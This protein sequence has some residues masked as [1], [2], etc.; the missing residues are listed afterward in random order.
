[1]KAS[2]RWLRALVPGL[3]ASPRELAD[4]FTSAGLEVEALTEFGIGT[5]QLV[6]AEV[7]KIEPHPSRAKLRLVTIDKGGAEQRVVCGAPNV[8]DPGHMVAFAPLGAHLPAVNMTL[9]PKDI[10]GVTSEGMLCSEAELGL[11][12]SGG[13]DGILVYAPG[14]AKAGTPLRQAVPAV[15]DWILEIGVTPNR[16]DALGHVG[17]AREAAA[18]F[19][20]PFVFPDPAA[21]KR[22]AHGKGIDAFA[23]VDVAD[24]ERCPIYGAA[25]VTEVKIG[26]SPDWLRYRLESLGV[27]AISNVVDITNLVLLEFGQPMHA[28]DLDRVRGAKIEVRRARDGEVLTTLDGQER[29]L[30]SD[31]LV[32]ADGE[33]AVALAGV[34]GGANSEIAPTTSRVLL[35]CAHFT[36]RGVRRTARRHAMHTEASHRF[37]RGVD[38]GPVPDVLAHAASLLTELA[39][40]AAVPGAILAGPGVPRREPIRLRAARMNR[41]IGTPVPMREARGILERLGFA[42]SGGGDDEL[43]AVPPT[44]RPDVS[45]EA[46][47]IEEVLRVRGLDSVPTR[48]PAISPQPPR[49]T[50]LLESRVRRAAVEVGLSE[51]VTYGF[52][53]AKEITALGAPRATITLMNP[54]GEERSVMRTTL[55]PGL[56][57]ALKRARRRGAPDCRLFT[58][59]PRFL[60][61]RGETIADSPAA[62]RAPGQPNLPDEVPSFAAVIAG[63]RGARLGKPE[64]VDVYDAKGV[65]AEIVERVTGRRAT[66]R[67]QSESAR[68]VHLHPRGAGELLVD[69]LFVGTFGPL[70][71][72]AAE[73][74][75][76]E[77][78]C[79]LVE[80]DLR[81]LDRLGHKVPQFAPIPNLPAATRD[82]AVVVHDDVTAGSVAEAIREAAEELCES[83]ELFD[84]FRGG[85]MPADHRSLAYHVVYRDPKAATDPEAART[86]TDEEV[87]ARHKAVVSTV[88]GRFGATLRA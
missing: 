82:I 45:M 6:M 71:P 41:L 50:G 57:E 26:P 33:G 40:G 76:V 70:H 29:K 2:H 42:V 23:R 86:L 79:M 3:D 73:A 15:H 34:M 69:G 87:D 20:L 11:V 77:G 35:E 75:E 16:P 31:D 44:H 52:V 74:L 67:A 1:M 46:D 80:L 60:A 56:L 53:S 30:D 85:N 84:L 24:G 83:V 55:L 18:L 28:F 65:A 10:G 17:L 43:A 59:G 21:P 62:K 68:S 66:V 25:M 51:A 32:I 88:T 13:H 64:D 36:P 38:P 72:D 14:T 27:R 47:L 63:T 81:A 49:R 12:A 54:L 39:G 5:A 7:R 9:T 48:L 78:P 58:I 61:A 19:E 22:V 8:P 37:E 4:R